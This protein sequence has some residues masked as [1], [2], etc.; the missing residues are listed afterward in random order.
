MNVSKAAASRGGVQSILF[1]SW[2]KNRVGDGEEDWDGVCC[3]VN[4]VLLCRGV[5][6]S[7]RP[8]ANLLICQLIYIPTLIYG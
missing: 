3:D 6:H 5:E 2:G 8:K 1:K 7:K 4:V